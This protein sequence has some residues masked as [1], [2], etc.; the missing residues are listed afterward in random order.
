MQIFMFTI[1]S[2]KCKMKTEFSADYLFVVGHYPIASAGKHGV[3]ECLRNG[4]K[5][6][7]QTYE[8]L[9]RMFRKYNVNAYFSGK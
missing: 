4:V 7:G 5:I 9:E 3:N 6:E 2:E 8:G 1:L